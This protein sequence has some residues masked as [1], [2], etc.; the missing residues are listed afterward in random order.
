MLPTCLPTPASETKSSTGDRGIGAS[1]GDQRENLAF[2]GGQGGQRVAPP[3]HELADDLG[4]DHG[5][6]G[7][8]AAQRIGEV[9]DVDHP[10]FEQVADA[11]AV[12]GVEQVG[13]VAV[14]DV[15]AER[16]DREP[17]WARRSS[18][19]ARSPS[20][21]NPGGIRM[22]VI[23]RSGGCS[24]TAA[25][26]APRVAPTAT[27]WNE[28]LEQPGGPPQQDAVLGDDDPDRG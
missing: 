16:D 20:S 4:V 23:T 15:L 12:A 1:L 2:A 7:G 10:V 19:A 14:L 11:A 27:V 9:L 6:A 5:R 28:T 17:G 8:D 24:A 26:R 13:G 21:V 3:P 22:S 18:T 25:V